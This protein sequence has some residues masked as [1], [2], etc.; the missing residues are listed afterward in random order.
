MFLRLDHST[1]KNNNFRM[2]PLNK[3][4]TSGLATNRRKCRMDSSRLPLFV[5]FHFL[6][7]AA[8]CLCLHGG[9]SMNRILKNRSD[10]GVYCFVKSWS[11]GEDQV[12]GDDKNPCSAV[13]RYSCRTRPVCR[14]RGKLHAK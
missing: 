7:G 8:F 14:W 13:S 1:T 6:W 4:N 11:L 3:N 12:A 2:K 10:C 9:T 5:D